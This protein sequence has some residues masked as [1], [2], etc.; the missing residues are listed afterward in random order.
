MTTPERSVEEIVKAVMGYVP[1]DLIARDVMEEELTQTLQAERQKRDEVVK[2]LKIAIC[3]DSSCNKE[4]TGVDE[5]GEPYQCQWCY[6]K[7]QALT[8]PNNPK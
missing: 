4:G 2:L 8:Q 6:E 5:Y 3:P 7:N 1:N